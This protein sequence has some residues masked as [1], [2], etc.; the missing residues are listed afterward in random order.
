MLLA[1]QLVPSQISRRYQSGKPIM[2]I[3]SDFGPLLHLVEGQVRGTDSEGHQMVKRRAIMAPDAGMGVG[4][5]STF[6]ET[7]IRRKLYRRV[8]F[9]S[10]RRC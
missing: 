9:S 8:L 4:T 6:G 2:S 5:E 3:R 10:Y 1:Q 7:E